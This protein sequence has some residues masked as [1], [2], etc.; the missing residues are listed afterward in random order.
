MD[1]KKIFSYLKKK[2]KAIG[3]KL[4]YTT[5]LLYYAFLNPQTPR[6]AKNIVMGAIGYLLTPLD[7]VVDFT[8]ILGY[9]D[10]LSILSFALVTIGAYVNDEVKDKARKQLQRWTGSLDDQMIESVE[11][12]L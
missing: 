10:D 11:K 9:T 8:P 6:W 5:L 4:T 2:I 12:V 3:Y 7:I 1:Q